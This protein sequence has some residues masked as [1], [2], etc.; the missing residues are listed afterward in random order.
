[1]EHSLVQS[2]SH[3]ETFFLGDTKW[4]EVLILARLLASI[5]TIALNRRDKPPSSTNAIQGHTTCKGSLEG[6]LVATPLAHMEDSTP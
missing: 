2:T 5:S 3:I 4:R 1:M 6:K